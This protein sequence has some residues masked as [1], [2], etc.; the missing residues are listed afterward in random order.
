[1]HLLMGNCYPCPTLGNGRGICLLELDPVAALSI[2]V[3]ELACPGFPGMA[4]R[5]GRLVVGPALGW[6]GQS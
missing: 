1:V 5:L 2:I 3:R 4:V 6:W